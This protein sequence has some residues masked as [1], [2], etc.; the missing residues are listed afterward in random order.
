MPVFFLIRVL[1]NQYCDCPGAVAV[2]GVSNPFIRSIGTDDNQFYRA[3]TT[4]NCCP[5]ADVVAVD[6][7]PIPLQR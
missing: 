7:N 5:K 2:L 3:I 6:V 1:V 4:A